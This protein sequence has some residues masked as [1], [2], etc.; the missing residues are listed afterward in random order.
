VTRDVERTIRNRHRPHE[1]FDIES[2]ETAG[3]YVEDRE[4]VR[5]I[6]AS[7]HQR[8]MTEANTATSLWATI[9][10]CHNGD[11]MRAFEAGDLDKC[12]TALRDPSANMLT[13]GMDNLN[14][15]GTASCQNGSGLQDYINR[16]QDFLLRL[17]EG[18]GAMWLDVPADKNW[19]RFS[20]ARP[21]DVLSAIDSVVGARVDSPNPFPHEFGL[22]T[23]RGV[24]CLRSVFAIYLAYRI[25]QLTS[26]IANPKI[27]EIG[28]GLGRSIYYARRFGI[29]DYSS[30]DLPFP[31]GALQAYFAMRTLGEENVALSGEA[32]RRSTV[33]IMTPAD[34]LNT[35]EHY[36]LI[37]NMDSITEI[38]PVAAKRYWDKIETSCSTFLSINHEVNPYRVREFA[39]SPSVTSYS[40]H[41]DWLHPGYVEEKMT[42]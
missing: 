5:R 40:R 29:V 36:D 28:A 6:V 13:F 32:S 9:Q 42:F 3:E 30:V 37:V 39:R 27:L 19:P 20:A 7:F 21:N 10:E 11:L 38:G 34:F 14:S 8:G 16:C 31:S 1:A 25:K 4:A 22:N 35:P 33:K 17:A 12:G 24:C 26:H 23:D 18:I 41:P 15:A 2:G